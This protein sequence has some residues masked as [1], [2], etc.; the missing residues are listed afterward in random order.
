MIE[1]SE[2]QSF[3]F[4]LTFKSF[5]KVGK[6]LTINIFKVIFSQT[7]NMLLLFRLVLIYFETLMLMLN[8]GK[9]QTH[10]WVGERFH[11]GGGGDKNRLFE[12]KSFFI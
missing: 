9:K 4:L 1:T 2:S 8:S 10:G 12:M 7:S 6:K 3:F 5:L 11:K